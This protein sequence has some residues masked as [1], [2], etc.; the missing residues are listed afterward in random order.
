MGTHTY[1]IEETPTPYPSVYRLMDW[2]SGPTPEPSKKGIRFWT[3][4]GQNPVIPGL[5][6]WGDM[7]GPN[8]YLHVFGGLAISLATAP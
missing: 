4:F 3:G 1:M 6:S 8:I 2:G 7:V 5:R